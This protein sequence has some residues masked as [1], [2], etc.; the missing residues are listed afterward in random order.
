MEGP[1]VKDRAAFLVGG[2]ASYGQY[3]L[4]VLDID[5]S[6]YFYDVNAK[7]HY[8]INEENKI[9]LSGYFGRDNFSL[10][11]NYANTYGNSVVNFRWNHLFS[12]KLFSN[13]SLIYSDYFF[14]L[15]LD[16]LGFEWKSNIRQWNIKYDIN[17]YINDKLQVN[18]GF[19]NIYYQFNPGAI[20]PL[21]KDSD[22]LEEQLTKKLQMNLLLT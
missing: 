15:E 18:Y 19:N 8:E 14:G 17:N 5:N 11:D 20:N 2:R 16:L 6:T 22:I 10:E 7:I 4:P 1:I 3:F 21:D 12:D 9:F 13:L